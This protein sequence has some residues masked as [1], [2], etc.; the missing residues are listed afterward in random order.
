MAR[1]G[2][3]KINRYTAEFK[4]T[5]VKLSE[6]PGV[7]VQDV[8][9]ALDVH[10]WMLSTWRTEVRKGLIKGKARKVELPASR[11]GELKLLRR[12]KA[13]LARKTLELEILKKAIRFCSDPT[14]K[15]SHS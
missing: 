5:A 13:Q 14:R 8:A 10:P 15:S 9:E 6:L 4:L 7:Q 12:Y 1:A 2:P 3:R 11:P